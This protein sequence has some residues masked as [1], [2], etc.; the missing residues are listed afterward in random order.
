MLTLLTNLGGIS[1]RSPLIGAAGTVG[2][3]NELADAGA[4]DSLGAVTSKSLTRLERV[5]N[6]VPRIIPSKV[7]M[8]NAIG[9]A[10]MGIDRF[11]AERAQDAGSMPCHLFASIAGHSVDDFVSVAERI[12]AESTI[13]LIEV[14]V[15]CPN[16]SDGRHFSA[17]PASL[18]ALLKVVR[19][20]VKRAKL[21]AKLPPDSDSV[22]LAAAAV[23]A[24]VDGLT[25]SNTMPAMAIEVHSRR[26]RLSNGRG[27]LSGPAI[28]PIVVRVVHDVYSQVSKGR[29]PI[30]GLGGVMNG[31][32]AAELVLAGAT[33]IGLGTVLLAE[34]SA[35]LRIASQLRSWVREQGCSNMSELVGQLRM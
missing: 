29:V 2:Y 18:S 14:N 30:I 27:G 1:L 23:D 3:T 15:S 5:G 16:T 22:A 26:A 7:G 32:D 21:F 35:P 12:D 6:A 28:H 24:G 9:L 33:A 34:P 25:L 10:N 19:A 17:D 8:L 11:L 31:E 20:N 13:P 4:L